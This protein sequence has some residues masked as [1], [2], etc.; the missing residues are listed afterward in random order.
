MKDHIV[1]RS[2]DIVGNNQLIREEL[3]DQPQGDTD[4]GNIKYTQK[5]AHF[6]VG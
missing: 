2:I 4:L 3:F 1:K 5:T 6:E